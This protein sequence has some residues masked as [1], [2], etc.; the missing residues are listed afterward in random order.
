MKE[1]GNLRPGTASKGFLA[2]LWVV[3]GLLFVIFTGTAG[4]KL[5]TPRP[6]LAGMIPWAGEVSP[7]FFYFTAAADLAGGLGILLPSLTRIR[8][9][10]TVLAALGCAAL[11]LCAVVFHVAR[12]EAA[13]TPFNVALVA[14]ALFVAWGRARAPATS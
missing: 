9:G 3:Q 4:W 10:L 1:S 11:Q 5:V 7:A 14:L 8:P 12:G 2:G 6:V 13:N